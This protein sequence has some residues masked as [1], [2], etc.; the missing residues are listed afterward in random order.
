MPGYFYCRECGKRT[1]TNPRLKI[2]QQYCGNKRCQQSRKNT[3]EREELIKNPFYH[4]RRYEQKAR[5]RKSRP[6]DQYQRSYRGS[7]P[8]YV[9]VNREKQHLRT[10][11][12]PKQHTG[13]CLSNIVKTDT[14]ISGKLINC[15]LYEIL[16][17]K[18]SP[19]KRIVKTDALIVELR[20]HRGIPK[21]LV[22]DS[23]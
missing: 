5:W 17:Y 7:H 19:G 8:D 18:T 12:N 9:K 6:V 16:P 1:R 2:R 15:G 23:G 20:A 22:C 11:N 3:W 10:Q 14:L 4:Q 13:D 21:V